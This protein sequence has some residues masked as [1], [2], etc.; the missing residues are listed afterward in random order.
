MSSNHSFDEQFKKLYILLLLY[1]EKTGSNDD[2]YKLAD[3]SKRNVFT[4]LFKNLYKQDG[5]IVDDNIILNFYESY[6]REWFKNKPHDYK[7]F[8][9]NMQ[10]YDKEQIVNEIENINDEQR[11]I[12]LDDDYEQS[13]SLRSRKIGQKRYFKEFTS[14]SQTFTP[15]S[16]RNFKINPQTYSVDDDDNQRN[17]NPTTDLNNLKNRISCLLI[18]VYNDV[19]KNYNSYK[20]N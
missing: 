4:E 15:S 19:N 5:T 18:S 11:K 20:T 12:L 1:R 17:I 10:H 9:I 6:K 8:F 3:E 2:N 13:R 16:K 14:S 7:D